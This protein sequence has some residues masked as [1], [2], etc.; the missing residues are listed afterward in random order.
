MIVRPDDYAR[1]EHPRE[2]R[3]GNGPKFTTRDVQ[4]AFM[5]GRGRYMAVLYLRLEK[6]GLLI[7]DEW[8]FV[9]QH[10]DLLDTHK[11]AF[12]EGFKAQLEKA[13]AAEAEAGG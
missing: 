11:S 6:G 7:P 12:M 5:H 2:P 4:Y 8:A 1:G 9:D 13:R 3:P 10:H